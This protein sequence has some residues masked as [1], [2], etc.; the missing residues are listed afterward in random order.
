MTDSIKI[1]PNCGTSNPATNLFC[2]TCGAALKD[3]P[4]QSTLPPG[5]RG[6]LPLSVLLERDNRFRSRPQQHDGAGVGTAW[7]GFLLAAVG[8]IMTPRSTLAKG[9]WA[10]G[11]VLALIGFWRMRHDRRAFARAGVVLSTVAVATLVIVGTQLFDFSELRSAFHQHQPVATEP[12]ATPDW[13]GGTAIAHASAT[14][15]AATPPLSSVA[16]FRGDSK[17]TGTEAGPGPLTTP[18]LLWKEDTAGEIYTSAAISNGMVYVGTKSGFLVAYDARSG[19]TKW[20]YDLGDYIVRS[21][22]A[23]VD[24]T[25]YVGAG[26]AVYAIDAEHG[27]LRWRFQTRYQGQS[28]PAVADGIVYIASQEGYIYAIDARTGTEDWH[29]QAEGLVFSSPAIANGAVIFGCDDGNVYA[30]GTRDGDQLWRF[31]TGGAVYSSPAVVN[32]IVY[33]ASQSHFLFALDAKSGSVIWH[34]GV[35]GSSSPA[36]ANGVV[37]FGGDDG[38]LY[39]LDARTG[40]VRWLF[41]TGNPVKSSP[42]VTK[43]AVYVA[44]GPLVF[45]V[46]SATGKERWRFAAKEPI[47]ASPAVANG[48][49][50]IG[51][52]DGYIYALGP[53]KK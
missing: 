2:P 8:L 33:V 5:R 43:D 22:P 24:N 28:S 41:P 13:M 9:L 6:S 51:S 17:R 31:P 14:A 4:A 47:D 30:I 26:F 29:Y 42:V 34:Y 27:T 38:G 44:S 52:Q 36:V 37:Y 49:L 20:R 10:G 53:V 18:E 11:I 25:V 3:V 19:E 45:A 40:A 23:V 7:I 48:H 21:S 50:F 16:M 32:G 39:A 1:C 35:G 15:H 12:T 46:N